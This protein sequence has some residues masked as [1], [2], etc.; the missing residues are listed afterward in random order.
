VRTAKAAV[1]QLLR[2]AWRTVGR[3]V[4]RVMAAAGAGLDRYAGLRRI[5]IDEISHRQGPALSHRGRRP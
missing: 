1:M 5:G 3:I 2:V 4:T